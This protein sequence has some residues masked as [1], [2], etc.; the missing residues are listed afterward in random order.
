MKQAGACMA[1]TLHSVNRTCS[2]LNA[3]IVEPMKVQVECSRPESILQAVAN[4]RKSSSSHG[5]RLT[6]EGRYWGDFLE[7]GLC[8]HLPVNIDESLDDVERI[9]RELV[10]FKI[11]VP[12]LWL[13]AR[14]SICV[15]VAP[16]CALCS[17]SKLEPRC[18]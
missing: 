5:Y 3:R 7:I 14:C 15:F 2:F 16:V 12:L 13:L 9:I 11:P 10:V 17:M 4:S 1:T 18:P 6:N 8:G